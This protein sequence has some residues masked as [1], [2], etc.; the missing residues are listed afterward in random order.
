MMKW[1][2]IDV[3]MLVFSCIMHL[4]N[5]QHEHGNN[6][7]GGNANAW[8][9]IVNAFIQ[10]QNGNGN[11]D[12]HG[13]GNHDQNGLRNGNGNRDQNGLQ[14]YDVTNINGLNEQLPSSGAGLWFGT[15]NGSPESVSSDSLGS[16]IGGNGNGNQ[17]T[18]FDYLT[19]GIGNG[20]TNGDVQNGI[21]NSNQASIFDYFPHGMFNGAMGGQHANGNGNGKINT[22]GNDV[23][24]GGG[25]GR[26]NDH[27]NGWNGDTNRNG[28]SSSADGLNVNGNQ[29]TGEFTRSGNTIISFLIQW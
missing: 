28:F 9:D 6:G 14:W 24:N 16:N 12:L 21:G 7:G 19:N 18:I 22:G 27:T 17:A 3:L 26:L 25:N 1:F 23:S 15:G 4:G 2:I 10:N 29:N 11:H 20:A 8:D 13:N 5:C